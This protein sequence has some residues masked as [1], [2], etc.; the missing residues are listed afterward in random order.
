MHNLDSNDKHIKS[1]IEIARSQKIQ[2]KYV[3]KEKLDKLTLN[4]NNE[5]IC[6]KTELR[7]YTELKK[8]NDIAK[9]LKKDKGNII[10]ML[11]RIDSY[12]LGLISRSSLHYGVDMTIIGKEDRPQINSS[13]A[14]ISSGASEIINLFSIKFIQQF[15]LGNID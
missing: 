1:I 5:G 13:I 7:Y 3:T 15:L 14:K 4:K 11:E 6:I 8:F 9:Y 12:N 2:I 10:L